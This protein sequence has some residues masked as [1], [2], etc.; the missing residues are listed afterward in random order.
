LSICKKNFLNEFAKKL[1]QLSGGG[2]ILYSDPVFPRI[3]AV[4][5]NSK[6]LG[7]RSCRADEVGVCKARAQSNLYPAQG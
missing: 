2:I 6:H 7:W 5:K 4:N 3:G 1:L